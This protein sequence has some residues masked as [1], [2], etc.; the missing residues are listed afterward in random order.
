MQNIT[1]NNH[2]TVNIYAE[3]LASKAKDEL[4]NKLYYARHKQTM[5][6]YDAWLKLLDMYFA[7]RFEDMKSFIKSCRGKG[8]KTRSECICCLNIIISG[9]S[10]WAT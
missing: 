10:K 9:G 4:L 8:G 2:G 6:G 7:G 3:D 1:I 5:G